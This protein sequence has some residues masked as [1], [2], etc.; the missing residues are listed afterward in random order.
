VRALFGVKFLAVWLAA[1]TLLSACTE[2]PGSVQ[3]SV[4]TAVKDS[5]SAVAT[6]RL[7]LRLEGS[8]KMTKAATST[9]LEDALNELQMARSAVL[10]LSPTVG[11]DRDMRGEA[12]NVLDGSIA[13]VTTARE[14]INSEDGSPSLQ[15]G[16]AQL[17]SAADRLSALDTQLGEK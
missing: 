14:A 10:R 9:A 5:S 11:K 3:D 1:S 7:A 4:A 12:L 6:A 16:D 17:G 8:A 2:V 15:D 13:G